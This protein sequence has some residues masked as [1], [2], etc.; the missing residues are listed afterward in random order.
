[1]AWPRNTC[2]DAPLPNRELE[3]L[4]TLFPAV[5]QT[6]V[7]VVL[8]L[9]P[10]EASRQL[11][12]SESLLSKE[13]RLLTWDGMR[14]VL[15]YRVYFREPAAA[16]LHCLTSRQRQLLHCLYLR[17][18]DGY[19]RQRHLEALFG[20]SEGLPEAFTTP[21]T[22]SL[23]GEYVQEILAVLDRQLTPALLASYV[24]L[25]NENPL[26]WQQTQGRVASYWDVYY[27]IRKRGA[28]RFRHYVG[29][30]ILAKLQQALRQAALN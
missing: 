13:C 10:L 23:L 4:A 11:A 6:E 22:F 9:L 21:F 26:Y 30:R 2:L 15:P 17:H 16:E 25:I 5:A 7:Q 27:R 3:R 1:M 28:P 14:L 19:V 8:G 12:T 29:A 24:Q 20:L 18:Y